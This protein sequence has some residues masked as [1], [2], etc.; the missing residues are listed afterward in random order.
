MC[1]VLLQTLRVLSANEPDY[2]HHTFQLSVAAGLDHQFV[3][4]KYKD[5]TMA[6]VLKDA[7][8]PF[9]G[10][11]FGLQYIYRPIRMVG[12]STGLESL[13]YGNRIGRNE[14]YSFTD[15]VTVTAVYKGYGFNGSIGVPFYVH[16]YRQISRVTIE[17][18]TGPEFFFEVYSM[19]KYQVN[20]YNDPFAPPVYNIHN[21]VNY[22]GSEIKQN[23]S[24]AWSVQLMAN[25]PVCNA[26]GI[27]V[28]PEW[29]FL[30]L[31]QLS[32][33][34]NIDY[35]EPRTVP[36]FLGVK[37]GFCLGTNFWKKAG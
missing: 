27:S 30:E 1:L 12:I 8:R 17:F 16:F 23:A 4:R 3:V 25:I 14:F 20:N 34:N 33:G 19:A 35:S 6:Q 9:A 21:T 24:L 37:V 31:K 11:C 28:G 26:F 5:P 13:E 32:A 10:F 36:F 29:K 18:A 2:K 15:Q 22:N 7:E